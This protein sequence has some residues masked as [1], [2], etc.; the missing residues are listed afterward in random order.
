MKLHG[1]AFQIP[2]GIVGM[3]RIAIALVASVVMVALS[4]QAGNKRYLVIMKGSENYKAAQT[5]FSHKDRMRPGLNLK[6][7]VFNLPSGAQVA[8]LPAT[9]EKS[10]NRLNAIV[11]KMDDSQEKYLR[12]NPGVLAVE[13]EIF[14]PAPRPVNGFGLRG[15]AV[16]SSKR[17]K[18]TGSGGFQTG[19]KTPWG[20]TAVKAVEAWRDSQ[21]G[22][23]AR[24]A[25]LDT[26]I[27]KDHP[28]LA[29]N[30]EKGQDF[31]CDTQTPYPF[32]DTIGHGTHVAGTIAAVATADGF[33]GVAPS[34]KILSGR[35]CS[36]QGCS[37]IAIAAGIDWALSEKVDVISMSLGGDRATIAE[38]IAIAQANDA[39]IAIVAAAGN[40]GT[41]TVSYPAALS[42]A[43]AV[44]AIDKNL[45]RATFSQ[46][47]PELA[48]VAPGV[49][50]VS[51]I[52]QGSG[53]E[54]DV[55]I[56]L[57]DSVMQH[58][59]SVTFEGA[60]DVPTPVENGVVFAGLGKP[61]DFATANV[62]GKFALMV[63]GEIKFIEKVQN[64][65]AAGALGA[66]IYNNAPGLIH[67]ALTQDGSKLP[68]PVFMI[69]QKPGEQLRDALAAQQEC[70]TRVAV[71][72]TDYAAL[73]GTSMATPHVSG[74]VALMK[75]VN[76]ALKP[77]DVKRIL[78]ETA[79]KLGPNDNNEFGAGLVNA[80]L[81]VQAALN[82]R[83]ETPA[84]P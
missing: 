60:A 65:I 66:I 63:R 52:P 45:Q 79:T 67:G 16:P 7:D 44:G 76:H 4:G 21:A 64:A 47:G 23:S 72:A 75:A 71:V 82:A 35:V 39:G 25:I 33:S 30:F 29:A 14:H 32:A 27:D 12:T 1:G 73:D 43:I 77:A 58:V 54:P 37:N 61:E 9:L 24:V 41:S 80:R 6:A 57:G 2:G 36:T 70:R 69:E 81:A 31:V 8:L 38:R 10:M 62:A 40:D 19:A 46:Y 59:T 78:Q 20:I 11:V 50:V 51:S 15:V 84:L 34:A 49:E 13:E 26:G 56:S 55:Q 3:K 28:A 42:E 74:V 48:V 53:R 83:V 5:V 68:V 22:L 17:A 18:V